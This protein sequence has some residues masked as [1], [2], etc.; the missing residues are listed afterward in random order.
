MN[1]APKPKK[2]GGPCLTVFKYPSSCTDRVYC[3]QVFP[4]TPSLLLS[5]TT[6]GLI[7]CDYFPDM[8]AGNLENQLSVKATLD[9][10]EIQKR[11]IHI[12]TIYKARAGC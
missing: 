8:F 10:M 7:R 2:V 1:L 11:N 4:I 5:F 6:L 12:Y 9:L 3:E